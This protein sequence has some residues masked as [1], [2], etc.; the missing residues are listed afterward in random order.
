MQA[1]ALAPRDDARGCAPLELRGEDD[2]AV[3]EDDDETAPVPK[4]F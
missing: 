1:N 3:Y 2:F 4:V